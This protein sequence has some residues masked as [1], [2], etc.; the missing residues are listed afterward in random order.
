MKLRHY[1]LTFVA[2]AVTLAN[3]LGCADGSDNSNSPDNPTRAS[4]CVTESISADFTFKSNYIQVLGSN[5]H[6][7]DE[8]EAVSVGPGLHYLME[9]Q[10]HRIGWEIA[11]WYQ[12]LPA[13]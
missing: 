10:P 6:Y 8:G 13:Q 4:S 3:C 9:D 2:I 1:F 12:S 7:I 11:R 5:M